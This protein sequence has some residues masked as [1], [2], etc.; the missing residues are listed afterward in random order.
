[1]STVLAIYKP[2]MPSFSSIDLDTSNIEIF[3]ILYNIRGE[4]PGRGPQLPECGRAPGGRGAA[5][6]A[7]RDSAPARPPAAAARAKTEEKFP[8]S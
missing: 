1:M 4:G 5:A 3:L 7:P 2:C 8:C 6:A